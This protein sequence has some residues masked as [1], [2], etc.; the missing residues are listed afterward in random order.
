[1]AGSLLC[2][3]GRGWGGAE[4]G[5]LFLAANSGRMCLYPVSVYV[6]AAHQSQ[7]LEWRGPTSARQACFAQLSWARSQCHIYCA[8]VMH[9]DPWPCPWM[10]EVKAQ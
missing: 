2:E 10:E 3:N 1:M 7:R 9:S 5:R 4:G 8:G 6:A